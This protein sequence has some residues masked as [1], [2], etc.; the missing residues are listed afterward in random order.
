[1]RRLQTLKLVDSADIEYSFKYLDRTALDQIRSE[2]PAFD[3]IIIVKNNRITDCSFANLVFYAD[4]GWV[5]SNTPLLKG[6][7]RQMYIDKQIIEERTITV[8][9]LNLFSKARIINAMIDLEESP[10]ILMENI[11]FGS[12]H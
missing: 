12:H 3:D 8:S 2:N 4:S 1:M 6:T 9:D 11:T 10:D 7:K 5:T